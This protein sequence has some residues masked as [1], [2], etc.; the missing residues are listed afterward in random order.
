M[1]DGEARTYLKNAIEHGLRFAFGPR[2]AHLN[3][4]RV[5]VTVPNDAYALAVDELLVGQAENDGNDQ[6][7]FHLSDVQG[8]EPLRELVQSI[9]RLL[10][11]ELIHEVA[12]V[13]QAVVRHHVRLTVVE[14]RVVHDLWRRVR[15][16]GWK[17]D[18]LTSQKSNTR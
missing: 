5:H 1:R 8:V 6:S 7:V 9:G 15:A 13:V 11:D 3:V 16:K 18:E 14:Q 10:A 2:C 17:C 4:E 12:R